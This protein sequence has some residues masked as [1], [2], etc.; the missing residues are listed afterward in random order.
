MRIGAVAM[1]QLKQVTAIRIHAPDFMAPGAIGNEDDVASVGRSRG[2]E[3]VG[4]VKCQLFSATISC[5]CK[6]N[7]IISVSNRNLIV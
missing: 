6:I 7:K 2:A 5:P 3:V 1:R 4:A